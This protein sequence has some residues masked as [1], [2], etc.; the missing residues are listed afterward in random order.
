MPNKTLEKWEEKKLCEVLNFSQG[1]QVDKDKQFYERKSESDV[2][3][4]RIIDFTQGNE[5]V[6]YI[7]NP[8]PNSIVKK[9]DISMVRYG[10]VGFVCTGLEGAIANNLFRIIPK[11]DIFNKRFLYYFFNTPNFQEYIKN[12]ILGLHYQQ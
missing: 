12:L 3:F 4:L 8:T 9:D 1:I 2:R 5:P 10:A 7:S 6:R 11:L